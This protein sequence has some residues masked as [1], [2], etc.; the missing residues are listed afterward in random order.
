MIV[1]EAVDTGCWNAITGQR[2]V[3]TVDECVEELRRGDP[4]LSGYV[5]VSEQDISRATVLPLPPEAAVAFRLEYPDA[6]RLDPGERDLLALART[7]TAEFELCSS[8]RAA[9]VAACACGWLDRVVSLEALT[10]SVGARP[11]RRLR[12][13]HTE[14]HIGAWRTSL[15]LENLSQRGRTS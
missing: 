13:Q 7:L 4:S 8:D 9:V 12:R 14:K 2:Q 15:R 1:I 3:V 6:D 5:A 10:A 11:W